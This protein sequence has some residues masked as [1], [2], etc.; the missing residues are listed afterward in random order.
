MVN[1]QN[2]ETAGPAAASLET[3]NG[4]R[5]ALRDGHGFPG[6]RESFEVDLQR[7][8][9]ASPET[10]LDAVAAVIVDYRGRIRLGQDPQ[11]GT[12]V[13]EGIDLAARLKQD[14]QGR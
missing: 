10:D 7:A 5:A 14:A 6:D 12:A 8:S 2:A 4:I 3:V 11:F 9:E 13:Q 1:A